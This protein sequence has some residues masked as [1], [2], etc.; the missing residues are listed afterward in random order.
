MEMEILG[1]A[2]DTGNPH[3]VHLQ[4]SY[5]Q[6]NRTSLVLNPW[7]D[8]DLKTFLIRAPFLKWWTDHSAKQRLVVITNWILA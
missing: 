5:K 7:C 2:T 1:L 6:N 4:C 3:L 8:F